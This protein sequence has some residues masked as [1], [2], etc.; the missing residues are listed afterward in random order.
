MEQMDHKERRG[1]KVSRGF[2]VFRV[3]KVSKDF[4]DQ[5]GLMVRKDQL[6]PL[7]HKERLV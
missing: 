5:L 3:H 2:K 7:E 1:R 4:K 6:V